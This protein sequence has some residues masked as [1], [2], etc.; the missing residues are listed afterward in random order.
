MEEEAAPTVQVAV[1]AAAAL[2]RP[3][4]LGLSVVDQRREDAREAEE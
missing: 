4:T 1:A 2:G 3:R